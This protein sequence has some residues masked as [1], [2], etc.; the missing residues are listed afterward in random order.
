MDA[1]G[2][3]CASTG[4]TYEYTELWGCLAGRVSVQVVDEHS[5]T[6]IPIVVT[7]LH[8]RNTYRCCS[9]LSFVFGRAVCSRCQ[10]RAAGEGTYVGASDPSDDAR[11][12]M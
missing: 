12:R 6:C 3:M 11:E 1:E 9:S 5:T 2:P 7:A 8:S 10:L 4:Q